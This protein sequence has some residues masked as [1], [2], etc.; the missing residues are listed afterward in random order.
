MEKKAASKTKQ[1]L[2]KNQSFQFLSFYTAQAWLTLN[3]EHFACTK[4][5]EKYVL[6]WY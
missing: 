1:M 4:F 5:K 6:T 3:S 2:P